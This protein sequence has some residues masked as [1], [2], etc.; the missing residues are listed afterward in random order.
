MLNCFWIRKGVLYTRY[1]IELDFCYGIS[2]RPSPLFYWLNMNTQRYENANS[3]SQKY[4]KWKDESLIMKTR[5]WWQMREST[6]TKTQTRK[7]EY[8]AINIAYQNYHHHHNHTYMYY[9]IHIQF[10]YIGV[11]T[12]DFLGKIYFLS[13]LLTL[14]RNDFYFIFR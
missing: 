1:F 5:T 13:N 6:I 9:D 2:S 3:K 14:P 8:N 7:Y 10:I 11:G 4:N 12:G